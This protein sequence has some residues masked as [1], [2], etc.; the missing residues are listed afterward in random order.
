MLRVASLSDVRQRI[1]ALGLDLIVSSP[2][3]FRAQIRSE[4]ARWSKIVRN[5]QIKL[6]E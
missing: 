2:A 4:L 5:A 1:D 3:E 6:S